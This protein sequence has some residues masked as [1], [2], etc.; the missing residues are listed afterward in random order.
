[1]IKV[2]L[3]TNIIIPGLFWQGNPRKILDLARE[4]KIRALSSKEMVEELIKVL[5][6]KRFSLDKEDIIYFVIDY[7]TYTKEVGVKEYVSEI[8]AD[9]FDNIFLTCAVNGKASYI[10]SG[11]HHLLDLGEYKGIKILSARKFLLEGLK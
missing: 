1:M 6:Y 4:G 9:P 3:D 5:S 11:D 7:K 10:V 8:K 2:V